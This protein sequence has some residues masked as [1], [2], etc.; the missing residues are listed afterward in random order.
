[1][2]H[3]GITRYRQLQGTDHAAGQRTDAA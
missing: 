3:L 2:T 1:M